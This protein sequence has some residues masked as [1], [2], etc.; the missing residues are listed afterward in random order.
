MY[1][2]SCGGETLPDGGLLNRNR[3]SNSSN[4]SGSGKIGE[5]KKG[6][7]AKKL[8][9]KIFHKPQKTTIKRVS[10][11][12]KNMSKVIRSN[13]SSSDQGLVSKSDAIYFSYQLILGK[14][15]KS[16]D[17]SFYSL[18]QLLLE[19]QHTLCSGAIERMLSLLED[20]G[21]QLS[22]VRSETDDSKGESHDGELERPNQKPIKTLLLIY[23][24]YNAL[25]HVLIINTCNSIN[26]EGIV[27]KR[28]SFNDKISNDD[29]FSISSSNSKQKNRNRIKTLSCDISDAFNSLEVNDEYSALL[30]L[31]IIFMQKKERTGRER[32]LL[33]GL[34]GLPTDTVN[35][36]TDFSD[37]FNRLIMGAEAEKRLAVTLKACSK[38]ILKGVY[39]PIAILISE[40][41]CLPKEMITLIEGLQTNFDLKTL[42]ELRNNKSIAEISDLWTLY[43]D[44]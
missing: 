6:G 10:S 12:D 32:G 31:L 19:V 28:S 39:M 44:R 14:C 25:L 17:A 38:R 29:D 21:S 3:S 24:A 27:A 11:L 7:V 20:I 33:L 2:A 8:S 43:M 26:K 9:S 4:Q 1:G 42:K 34:L 22:K 15:R 36:V 37:I 40:T 41:I 13:S 23:D 5:S 35:A 18:A 30:S 16:T